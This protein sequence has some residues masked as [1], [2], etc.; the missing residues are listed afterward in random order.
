MMAGGTRPDGIAPD[1]PEERVPG[2]NPPAGEP[3]S[4]RTAPVQPT[5]RWVRGRQ[6]LVLPAFWLTLVLLAAGAARIGAMLRQS[7]LLYPVATSLA[8][9]LFAA[10]AVPFVL[11]VAAFDFLEREPVPLL[12]AAFG[13]GGLVAT[14]AAIPG[15]LALTDVLA[16]LVSPAFAATWGLAA[17]A[18]PVE[19]SV[20]ALGVAAIV[21]IARR[22]I[23]SVLD[24]AVY[25]AFVGLGFQV[26]EDVVYAINAVALGAHSD[27][28][29]PVI[30][31]FFLRGF[32]A[33]LWSHTLF[34]A[35]A[36][37]GIGYFV[38]R[39]D[40]GLGSRVGVVALALLGACAFHGL[41]N[42]PWLADGF[43]YGMAGVLFAVLAKGLPAL[44]MIGL[45]I[46]A[47]RRGEAAYYGHELSVLADRR[48][49][50]PAEI[51]ALGSPLRRSAARRYAYDRVGRRGA[52][53][54]RR[55]QRAQARLAVELS[56]GGA[57]PARYTDVLTARR[58]LDW[59]GHPEAVAPH[60]HEQSL[61]VW[62]IG[63][64]AAVVVP[65]LA[66]LGIRALG[67]G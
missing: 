64:A 23:N 66:A 36:G 65:I 20:K 67:G 41:W 60:D 25:G 57:R 30:V 51:E 31:T 61:R 2:A 56:R 48:F 63:C 24:G 21:L 8:V 39:R 32:L 14:S 45:L 19:E 52:R 43:G 34:S 55:L 58:Q 40:R 15:D 7:F 11:L 28:V 47:A 16:K 17:A 3:R 12:A 59:C 50:T 4:A 38:V 10:Y 18:P 46:Q 49:A 6:S 13:W 29:Q 5:P 37:A 54:V 22:Q 62:V 35:L 27:M 26:V 44:V 9:I 53:A 42:S 33:G 1:L